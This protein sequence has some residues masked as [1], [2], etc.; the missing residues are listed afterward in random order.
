MRDQRENL[1]KLQ[2]I[3]KGQIN[4]ATEVELVKNIFNRLKSAGSAHSSDSV[5]INAAE[6]R[7]GKS[8]YVVLLITLSLAIIVMGLL[9]VYSAVR[10]NEDYQYSKQIIGVVIGIIITLVICKFDYKC[11]S[12]MLIPLIIINVVLIMSPHI[13]GLGVSVKGAQS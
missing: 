12:D 4:S 11:L 10:N 5:N 13:P 8:V 1:K 6:Q 7:Y 2:L 3:V 9:V